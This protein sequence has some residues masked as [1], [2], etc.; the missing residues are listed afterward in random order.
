[1]PENN[2]EYSGEIGGWQE[3]LRNLGIDTEAIMA[4]EKARAEAALE[5]YIAAAE[6]VTRDLHRSEIQ[7]DPRRGFIEESEAWKRDQF[8]QAV[9]ILLKWLPRLDNVRLKEGIVCALGD[10]RTPGRAAHILLEEFESTDASNLYYRW[11]IGN[12]LNEFADDDVF[13]HVARIASD[14]EVG[15]AREMFVA[16]LGNMHDER[17]VPLPLEFLEDD[18]VAAHALIGLRKKAGKELEP[19]VRM[20]L[21]HPR[22]GVRDEAR[23]TLKAIERASE[24]WFP[25]INCPTASPR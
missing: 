24:K 15:K 22:K 25:P 5:D 10:R 13:A 12:S 3:Q 1:M 17:A 6:P 2:N 7:F 8:L 20:L 18:E 11:A 4:E 9:D 21:E 16:A 14:K 23:K 19:H